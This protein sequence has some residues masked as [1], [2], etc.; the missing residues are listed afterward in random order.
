M[1]EFEMGALSWNQASKW[2][3]PKFGLLRNSGFNNHQKINGA[4]KN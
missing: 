3:N 1:K 2:E 4:F